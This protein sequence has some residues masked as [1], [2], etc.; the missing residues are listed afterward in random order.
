MSSKDFNVITSSHD[1]IFPINVCQ[2][3]KTETFGVKDSSIPN[4]QIAA[5]VRR[6]HGDFVIGWVLAFI[7]RIIANS[8]IGRPTRPWL[9]M[10]AGQD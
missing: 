1:E 10:T 4:D 9:S 8:A 5:F 3:V 7:P 2:G 6:G